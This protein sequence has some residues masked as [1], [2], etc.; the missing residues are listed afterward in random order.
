MILLLDTSSPECRLVLVKDDARTEYIWQADRQLADGLLAFLEAK[1][2]G[3]DESLA[4]IQGIGVLKGPGSFTGLRIGLSVLNAMAS[5][6]QIPIVGVIGDA[7]QDEA[8]KRLEHGE[9]DR[10]VVPE[11]GQ[12]ANIT[13]PRK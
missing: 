3:Q 12:P 8:L 5:D 1:L 4:T 11:Y 10:I 2:G 7:W 6:L 13:K 9:D